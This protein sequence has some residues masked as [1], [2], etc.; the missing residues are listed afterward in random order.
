MRA[1]V[2][3]GSGFV[4]KHLLTAL[5]KRGEPARALARSPS[6]TE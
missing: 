2:T 5:A 4:G 3:G 1:F 6:A